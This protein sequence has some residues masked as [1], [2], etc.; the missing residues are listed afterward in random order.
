MFAAPRLT[1]RKRR[2]VIRGEGALKSLAFLGCGSERPKRATCAPGAPF[3]PRRFGNCVRE[4]NRDYQ[5]GRTRL[6]LQKAF[7]FQEDLFSAVRDVAMENQSVFVASGMRTSR[8]TAFGP[9]PKKV[10][11]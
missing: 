2:F 11:T 3:F 6:P 9:G 7:V 5:T 10:W 4:R 1:K 8:L